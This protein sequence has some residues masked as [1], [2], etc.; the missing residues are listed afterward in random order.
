MKE[1]GCT[2]LTIV[3]EAETTQMGKVVIVIDLIIGAAEDIVNTITID[4]ITPAI[5]FIMV[6]F[7]LVIIMTTKTATAGIGCFTATITATAGSGLIRVGSIGQL[8]KEWV[9]AM[10]NGQTETIWTFTKT[11]WALAWLWKLL[12]KTITTNLPRLG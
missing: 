2:I 12:F 11:C 9:I 7:E 8:T 3:R 6:V 5:A 1:S 10:G 4:I